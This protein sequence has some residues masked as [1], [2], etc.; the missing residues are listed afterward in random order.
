MSEVSKAAERLPWRCP[1]HPDA[2]IRHL[3]DQNHCVL[4]GYPGGTGWQSNHRY[5]C[6]KC[7]R[8]VREPAEL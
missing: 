6:A 1:E 5:E 8:Q 4:N 2:M 7:G 3:Y